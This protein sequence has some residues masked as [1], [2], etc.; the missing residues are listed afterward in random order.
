MSDA[1]LAATVREAVAALAAGDR[2]LARFGAARHRYELAAPL[3]AAELAAIEDE[4]GV[5]PEELRAFVHEIGA[6]GAGPYHGW[7]PPARA[8]RFVTPGGASWTRALPVAHLGCG[9]VA[10]LPLDGAARGEV[11]ID[12]RC[13]GV[14][15]P[16]ANTFTAF[17][18]DWIDRL[19]HGT[20]PQSFVPPGACALPAALSGYLAA[21]EAARGLAAGSL[22]GAAL[23]EALGDL[24]PGAIRI[25][26]DATLGLFV[27]G[28]P[29][30][31]CISCARTVDTLAADGLRRDAVAPGLAPLPER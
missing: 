11:W 27:E 12:A 25:G 30:D 19:A 21:V 18:L 24:G 29:V 31:P 15:A 28:D 10:V 2:T 22:E 13:V 17:Y 8:A 6:G 3:T 4:T 9:Y 1:E 26:A 7:I 16:I 14:V 20:W 23:R 5:L